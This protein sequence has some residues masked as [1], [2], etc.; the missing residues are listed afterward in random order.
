MNRRAFLS[1]SAVTPLAGLLKAAADTPRPAPDELAA[2]VV[3]V[4]GGVGGV[5]C[6]LGAARNGR[7]VILTEEFD[8]IGGQL[9]SQAVPP[10]EYPT[11]ETFPCTKLYGSFRTKVRD[12]YRRHYPLNAAARALPTLN[13]GDGSVSKLCHEPR[14]AVAVLLELLAPHISSGRVR[15]LAARPMRVETDRDTIT[16]VGVVTRQG[17][18]LILTAPYFVDATETGDLLALGRVEHVT[19]AESRED[20]R[21][22]HAPL[23]AQPDNHQAFTAC[24]AIDYREGE[25]HTIEK[26]AGYEAF[27]KRYE[28]KMQPAW[29]GRL[30]SWEAT[31]PVTMKLRDMAFDPTGALPK[32]TLNLW[33]Y[34]RIVSLANFTEGSGLSDVCLVNWPQNDYW[35]GNLYG[36]A[37]EAIAAH[38]QAAKDLSLSLLYWM[39]TEAP[40]PGGRKEG[41]K[42]L[43]LRPDIVGTEDGLA[44]AP[45]VRESRRI[46]AMFTVT[47][48]HVGTDARAR[49]TGKKPGEFAAESFPDS[50]GIGSYRIDLHP[51]TGGDNYIDVSSLPFQVPLG[52]LIPVRV[53]N[54]LPACKNIGT[55]H[56]TNGSYR[57]HPVEWTIGEAV[58]EL[59]SFCL[60]KKRVPRQV[61][62]DEEL[63]KDF[64]ATLT[65]AGFE[66]AWPE[67]V[68][69]RPR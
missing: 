46:K 39:Q 45:Y 40:H 12:Y 55:T 18:G 8:W 49:A 62:R 7:S 5:A 23:V 36:E 68:A 11:I 22:P 35:L 20:T 25:D 33:T 42:G 61:R 29:P 21:E 6:A 60:A 38:V 51:S 16:A 2:D 63:R 58:G 66:L 59:V 34:R 14:V 54:L 30:L 65:K 1:L 17:R 9:T 57:L 48:G 50:V 4:G 64:Q 27:W 10:D 19:G 24:F 13:P 31:H 3:V 47:E 67:D 52:A 69:K 26:P 32:E 15:L 41:W 28:P 43:R 44:M 56:I 37:P 53:E